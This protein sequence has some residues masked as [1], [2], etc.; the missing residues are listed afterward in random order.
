LTQTLDRDPRKRH[1]FATFEFVRASASNP[2]E[3]DSCST[4]QTSML[5]ANAVRQDVEWVI[6]IYER[7]EYFPVGSM[8]GRL[9]FDSDRLEARGAAVRC[10]RCSRPK[11]DPRHKAEDGHEFATASGPAPRRH[12]VGAHGEQMPANYVVAPRRMVAEIVTGGGS[13]GHASA[14]A[15]TDREAQLWKSTI[16]A[17][18]AKLQPSHSAALVTA[19]RLKLDITANREKWRIY[20]GMLASPTKR[21]RLGPHN[22][23]IVEV[24]RD[25]AE[26]LADAQSSQRIKITRGRT[27]GEAVMAFW[28]TC[29]VDQATL[30]YCFRQE[31]G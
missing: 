16:A 30:A 18:L 26:Q 10:L 9:V 11:S 27:Y 2:A 22:C 8:S 21:R 15:A 31:I 25:R 24:S 1:D 17:K 28:H 7:T 14:A 12:F 13:H 20:S 6:E 4:P 5:D 29:A 3:S 19:A 23:R